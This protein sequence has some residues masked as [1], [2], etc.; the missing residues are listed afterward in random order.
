MC[1]RGAIRLD[2]IVPAGE[3]PAMGFWVALGYEHQ[4]AHAR[5]I[6]DF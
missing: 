3:A 6:R 1:E 2:A 4:A 5:F